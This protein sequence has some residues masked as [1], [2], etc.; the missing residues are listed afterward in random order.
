MIPVVFIHRGYQDYLG[1][2]LTQ[3]NK[4]N[5]VVLIGDNKPPIESPTFKF[6]V[7]SENLLPTMVHIKELYGE[8]FFRCYFLYGFGC[9]VI[10]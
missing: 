3:A 2:T 6:E 4:N 8:K 10:R 9:D 7:I 5:E 1:Y